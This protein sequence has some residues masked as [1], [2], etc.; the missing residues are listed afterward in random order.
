V[1]TRLLEREDV[2]AQ[3]EALVA[4]ANGGTGGAILLQAS[5]GMGKTA[6]LEALRARAGT[7]SV[8]AARGSDLEQN[9]PLGVVRQLLEPVLRSAVVDER[10]RWLTGAAAIA[11]VVL[12][13][14]TSGSVEEGA[15]FNA[16][17]WVVAAMA[18]ERPALIVVDDL[19]WCDVESLRWIGFVVRRLEG[20]PVAIVLATRSPE[21]AASERAF[22]A[23][24]EDP[25]LRTIALEPLSE[26]ATGALVRG[27][28]AAA[29]DA[30]AGACHDAS[31]GNPFLL[32]EL[33]A[34]AHDG[35]VAPNAA[36]I[37][38]VASLASAGLQRAVHVRLAALG[39]DAVDVARATAL[40][41]V[42]ASVSLVAAFTERPIEAVATTAQAL[43]RVDLLAPGARL[44][45]RHALLR[46]AVLAGLADVAVTAGHIRAARLLHE[47]SAP[48]EEIA[49][50][51]LACD[52]IGEGWVPDVL[53]RAARDALARA[54]P[55]LAARLL[56][57]ALAEPIGH[58]RRALLLAE[59][60]GALATAGD[61]RAID[62][63]LGVTRG[64]DDPLRRAAV[65]VRLT[66][67]MWSSGRVRE[68]PALIADARA[69]L[70][71]GHPEL[72][73]QLASIRAAAAAWG[74]GEPVG[75]AVATALAL[76]PEPGGD[77]VP[78]RLALAL[79][80]VAGAFANRP[81]R[82]L[83]GL[84]RRAIGDADAYARAIAAGIPL[85]PAVALLHLA[86]EADGVPAGF[87]DIEAAQR[88][89][90]ALALGLSLTLGWRALC[91]VRRGAL[92]EGEA[93][94]RLA[95]QTAPAEF[96]RLRNV[97]TA[98]LARVLTER[99]F[100]ERALALADAQLPHG[101]PGGGEETALQ[102][103]R[104]RILQAL[105]R[106]RE[107]AEAALAIGAEA[108]ALDSE[109]AV[110]LWPAVAA[111]ALLELGDGEQATA[112]AA[113]A[114]VLA[115]RFGVPGPIGCALRVLGLA[116]HDPDL[117]R[118]AER[119]LA[120]SMMRL[121][122]AR[123][124]VDLGAALRR[125][126]RRQAAREPLAAG[127]ELAHSCAANALVARAHEELRAAGARPRSVVR[128]GVEALTASELRAARLAAD[129]LTNREIAQHLFVTQKTIETQ[130]RAAYR[131]LGVPGRRE[132]Q[133]ALGS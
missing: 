108:R 25:A 43:Q 15:A 26:A 94:A 88:R 106:P 16:L 97:S 30:F 104:A 113:R 34:A 38:S 81:A 96:A 76:L 80:G 105:R 101:C 72:V 40:L 122:H 61:P 84:A 129:G 69:E 21:P 100:P 112:L 103:E 117:L 70:P 19:H 114:V 124:L 57:R 41:G 44:S 99:G 87:D 36:S 58:D 120:G 64:D 115:R 20:L 119:T 14:G 131:K 92:L 66:I 89:R 31:G 23:L 37:A 77:S 47:R 24:Q 67:P 71:A 11:E 65:A 55:R 95:L 54:S 75:P 82:E 62:V 46:A 107:A 59:T 5:A 32:R 79:L 52:P 125:E 73:F 29:D 110:L 130:L 22:T 91:S 18:A 123:S 133:S 48:A 3:I 78:T 74:S 93:D 12:H 111:E 132:L 45:F 27:R 53:E 7:M 51:L 83:T 2:L 4:R 63:L 102:L 60:G 56:E 9:F 39:E 1:T 10:E 8:L 49:A 28:F 98:A 42:D 121:E 35:G 33:L 116:E 68:L 90:G 86:E 109:S 127:M 6:L 13:G 50:H 128:S 126:G 118:D 17:Y 85:M